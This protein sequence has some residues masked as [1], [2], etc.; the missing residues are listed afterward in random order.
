[1]SS[2]A[3]HITSEASELPPGELTLNTTALIAVSFFALLI[4]FT[5]VCEPITPSSLLPLLISPSAY[6]TAIFDFLDR[7]FN[8]FFTPNFSRYFLNVTE[9]ISLSCSKLILDFIIES[10]S[11][12]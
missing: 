1:M 6:I 11:S 7:V 3:L 4:A 12:S 9:L 2:N 8:S 10:N 5:M